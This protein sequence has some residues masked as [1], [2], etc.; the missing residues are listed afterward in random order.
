[1]TEKRNRIKR[2]EKKSKKKRRRRRGPCCCWNTATHFVRNPGCFVIVEVCCPDCDACI[3]LP[4][5]DPVS[6]AHSG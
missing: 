1:M 4:S 3:K 5:G 6:T 2:R